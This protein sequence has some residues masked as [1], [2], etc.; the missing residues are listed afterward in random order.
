M[1]DKRYKVGIRV[2]VAYAVMLGVFAYLKRE[3][4]SDMGPNEWG[5]F[6][7]GAASPLAFLWLVL[8]YLQQGEELRQN[9]EALCLQVQE[10]RD[11]VEQQ[12]ALVN[13]TEQQ[14]RFELQKERVRRRIEVVRS[15]PSFTSSFQ[16]LAPVSEKVAFDCFLDNVGM[17]A[18]KVS[19][20]T[21][22]AY[23]WMKVEP[24]L[25]LTF[26]Q[27]SRRNWTLI[28]ETAAATSQGFIV[29]SYTDSNGEPQRQELEVAFVRVS[30]NEFKIFP[31][32]H[33]ELVLP[34][35]VDA[36]KS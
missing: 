33:P 18:T 24:A 16:A 26:D 13:A 5:D 36:L 21:R 17:A 23:S 25:Y 29:I 10:L 20:S 27:R 15:Q 19:V 31:N 35:D 12:K 6:L 7:A 9:T 30:D 1:T 22:E 28:L 3:Q 34:E 32:G 11:S 8:G 4:M 2:T 14:H